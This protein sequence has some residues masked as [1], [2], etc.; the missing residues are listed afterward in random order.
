MWLQHGYGSSKQA[1][2]LQ[3]TFICNKSNR[4]KLN[5]DK[6]IVKQIPYCNWQYR[7]MSFRYNTLYEIVCILFT[8]RPPLVEMLF[9]VIRAHWK[10]KWIITA[11]KLIIF[12]C[13]TTFCNI[14]FFIYLPLGIFSS[15]LYSSFLLIKPSAVQYKLSISFR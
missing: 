4:C 2:F 8:V 6:H 11:F 9:N 12:Y 15:E 10:Q 1:Y 7:W 5:L 13:L 3:K 14:K